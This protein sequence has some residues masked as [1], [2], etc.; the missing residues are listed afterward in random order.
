M[1]YTVGIEVVRHLGKAG[2]P[3]SVVIFRH[4]LPIVYRKAPILPL[5]REVIRRSASRRAH[6]EQFRILPNIDTCTRYSNRKVALQH[7]PLRV[8]IVAHLAQ[9][10]IEMIL[11][12]VVE[13]HLLLVALGKGCTTLLGILCKGLPLFEICRAI[14]ISQHREYSIRHQPRTVALLE[15]AERF[16]VHTACAQLLVQLAQILHFCI[17]N[18]LVVHIRQCVQL[19]LQSLHLGSIRLTTQVAHIAQTDIEWV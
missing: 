15:I 2:T 1:V 10:A 19:L 5:C 7:H 12:I 18:T 17:Y 3:P 11:H 9:L 14:L 13:A 16:A 8:E 4:L 6:I